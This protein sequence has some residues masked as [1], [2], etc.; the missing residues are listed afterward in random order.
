MSFGS[1]LCLAVALIAIIVAL[2][3][4]LFGEWAG[5]ALSYSIVLA[6]GAIAMRLD[7]DRP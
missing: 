2:T 3:T 6:S 4:V 7:H 5:L 1:S